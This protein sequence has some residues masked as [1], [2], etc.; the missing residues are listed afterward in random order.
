MNL[1]RLKFLRNLR[2]VIILT[3]F[4]L[5]ITALIGLGWINYTGLPSTWRVAIENEL[6]KKGIEASITRLRYI[7]LRGVEASAV[8][9]YADATRTRSI[10][11][12]E[13]LIFDLDK[14]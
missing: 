9:V 5:F 8:T 11:H 1:T 10:A 13:R 14:I 12:L 6:S 4:I 7:P 2:T 3:A